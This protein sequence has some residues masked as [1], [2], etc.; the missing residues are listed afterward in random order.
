MGRTGASYITADSPGVAVWKIPPGTK[1]VN[2]G[3][4]TVGHTGRVHV[5]VRGEEGLPVYFQRDPAA[6]R[7]EGDVLYVAKSRM[8]RRTNLRDLV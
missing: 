3:T 6:Q 7:G 8:I 2:G 5:L 4:V 1:Y